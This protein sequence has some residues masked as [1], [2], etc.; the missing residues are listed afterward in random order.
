MNRLTV[1][2]FVTQIPHHNK[3]RKGCEND[4]ANQESAPLDGP[5]ANKR[6]KEAGQLTHIDSHTQTQMSYLNVCCM[7]L[8]ACISQP[9]MTVHV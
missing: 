5:S 6:G 3:N 2:Q 7:T 1:S 4:A 9:H 8:V